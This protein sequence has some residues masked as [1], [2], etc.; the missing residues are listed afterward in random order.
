MLS[1]QEI[2]PKLQD[3]T[4]D[5]LQGHKNDRDEQIA[6]IQAE[7]K[8]IHRVFLHKTMQEQQIAAGM[9]PD[10]LNQTMLHDAS[11]FDALVAKFGLQTIIDKVKQLG[12]KL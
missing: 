7:K 5:E 11:T 1:I 2:T 9:A 12:G 4:L 6:L 8:T 10:E 3:M